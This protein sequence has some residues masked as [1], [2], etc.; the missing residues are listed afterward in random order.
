MADLETLI[1]KAI[2]D[3]DKSWFNENYRSQAQNVLKA[4]RRAGFEVV[5]RTPSNKAVE[6]TVALM[7]YGR[8]RPNDYIQHVYQLMLDHAQKYQD[9]N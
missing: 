2:K 1:A 7:P 3:A 9:M 6:E 8:M 4:L 5:P